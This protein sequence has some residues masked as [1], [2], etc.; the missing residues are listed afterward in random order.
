MLPAQ[1]V[2]E[3]FAGY[4]PEARRLATSQIVLLRKLPLG[5]VP[6]L[7][8]ELIAYDFKF[9]AERR[10]LD[11]QFAYLRSLSPYQLT[12]AVAAF[13]QLRLS[14]AL[15]KTDWVNSPAIFTEQLTA[16]LW[17]THQIDAFSNAAVEYVDKSRAALPEDP[18]PSHR[19]G[20]AVIGQGV[21]NNQYRLFRKLRPLGTSFKQVKHTD[22]LSVLI[23]AVAKRAVAHPVPYGHWYIDGGGTPPVFPPGVTGVSYAALSSARAAIQK[24]MQ[25][26][27]EASVFD[28]EVFRTR[29]A[30]VQ[31]DDV[32]MGSGGDALLTRFV[33]S[34]LTEGS[35][36]QVFSTT[37]VQWSAREALRRAQPVTLLTRFGPRQ[38]E[39]SMNELLA[40]T[41][42]PPELDPQGSLID[43]D[44][45]AYYN[46][47]NLQRLSF[48][49]DA[50]FLAW[51][52]DQQEAV[53]IGPGFDRGASSEA[54][55]E[56]RDLIGRL[57]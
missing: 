4:P 22:G 25:T 32:G 33:L 29:M 10:E 37:F 13:S 54:P 16:H 34:L 3:S 42:R 14:A 20:I 55:I 9:P 46:W 2:S 19:L 52:E 51:F 21:R 12:K 15:E 1:L 7:L 5:F 45:G 17:T 50:A 39:N 36:T 47:L 38:R 44:I 40:E 49:Q 35:G 53:A 56:L 11:G 48:A 23:E 24:R 8:R 30:Q 43:A 57:A 27:Y 6:L 28:P 31:P 41:V 26:F 18:L